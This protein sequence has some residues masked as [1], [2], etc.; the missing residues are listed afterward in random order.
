MNKQ[1]LTEL[2][3]DVIKELYDKN[4]KVYGDKVVLPTMVAQLSVHATLKI[5]EEL[6]I[7]N[8]PKE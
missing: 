3:H 4:E 7:L 1:E 6:G 2:V 5:L 8:L